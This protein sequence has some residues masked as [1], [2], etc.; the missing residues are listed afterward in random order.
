ME[1]IIATHPTGEIIINFLP[2]NKY[3]PK[4][5]QAEILLINSL[6]IFVVVCNVTFSFLLAPFHGK[7]IQRQEIKVRIVI[8]GKLWWM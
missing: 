7:S 5:N 2:N 4:L 8:V 6:G 1:N 3:A